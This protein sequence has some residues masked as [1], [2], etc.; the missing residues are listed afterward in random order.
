ME[1]VAEQSERIVTKVTNMLNG[2]AIYS[3]R[4]K[5]LQAKDLKLDEDIREKVKKYVGH[6][7]RSAFKFCARLEEWTSWLER[8]PIP[9]SVQP[10]IW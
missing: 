9:R 5:D 4:S 7:L 10:D 6:F 1:Y 2:H 3:W 8:I